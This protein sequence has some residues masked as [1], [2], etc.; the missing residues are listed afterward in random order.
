MVTKMEIIIKWL[1]GYNNIAY[2][3]WE[4]RKERKSWLS[5][6]YKVRVH[7]GYFLHARGCVLF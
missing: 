5:N 7:K 3:N 1:S 6:W 4:G 2:L